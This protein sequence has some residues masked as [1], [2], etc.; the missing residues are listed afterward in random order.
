MPYYTLETKL[1]DAEDNVS[2]ARASIDIFGLN[3]RGIERHPLNVPATEAAVVGA[4]E[5]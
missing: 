5:K 1:T 3:A 2:Y 4:T